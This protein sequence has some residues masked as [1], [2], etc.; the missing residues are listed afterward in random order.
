M[1]K[2]K[3]D[4][5]QGEIS[6]QYPESFYEQP[7]IVSFGKFSDK[8]GVGPWGY[9]EAITEHGYADKDLG[10]DWDNFTPGLPQDVDSDGYPK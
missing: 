6:Q 2:L 9:L 10:N 5:E 8:D 1:Y 3:F 7:P 4:L